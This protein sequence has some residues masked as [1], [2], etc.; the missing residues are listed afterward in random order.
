MLI[1][2]IFMACVYVIG[3]LLFYINFSLFEART[4]ASKAGGTLFSGATT[5]RTRIAFFWSVRPA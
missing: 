1:V 5:A 4:T 2:P 3:N